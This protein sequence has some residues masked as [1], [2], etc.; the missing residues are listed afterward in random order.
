MSTSNEYLSEVINVMNGP[1]KEYW[2]TLQSKNKLNLVVVVEEDNNKNKCI[3]TSYKVS[4]EEN[5]Y[6]IE[7]ATANPTIVNEIL[8]GNL[9]PID[10]EILNKKEKT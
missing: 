9:K 4:G 5:A 10:C 3:F 7:D 6:Y 8:D 1:C 2:A